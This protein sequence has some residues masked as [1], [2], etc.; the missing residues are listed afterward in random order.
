MPAADVERSVES[1]IQTVNELEGI[2]SLKDERTAVCEI[3]VGCKDVFAVF[4]TGFIKLLS[5]LSHISFL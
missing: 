4:L 3:I 2:L 1:A 5:A